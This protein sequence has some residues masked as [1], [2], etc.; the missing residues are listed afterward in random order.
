MYLEL[1]KGGLKKKVCFSD[2]KKWNTGFFYIENNINYAEPDQEVITIKGIFTTLR[3]MNCGFMNNLKIWSNENSQYEDRVITQNGQV[4]LY[5]YFYHTEIQKWVQ[6]NDYQTLE[7]NINKTQKSFISLKSKFEKYITQIPGES[8]D[9]NKTFTVK[10]S[11]G[12]YDSGWEP[13]DKK[14]HLYKGM[15]GI[16]LIKPSIRREKNVLFRDLYRWNRDFFYVCNGLFV[17]GLIGY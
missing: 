5:V 11:T 8:I 9:T 1:H 3:K 14:A 2:L 16:T 15:L 7:N 10:R 6:E 4:C 17:C 13:K 12:K